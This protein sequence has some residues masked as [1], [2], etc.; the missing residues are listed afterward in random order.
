PSPRPNRSRALAPAGDSES[1]KMVDGA[2]WGDA[3][4]AAPRASTPVRRNRPN[5][6]SVRTRAPRRRASAPAPAPRT[7]PSERSATCRW[8]RPARIRPAGSRRAA[9]APALSAAAGPAVLRGRRVARA[10]GRSGSA[11]VAPEPAGQVRDEPRG[12][13]ERG[14]DL[15]HPFRVGASIAAD[16]PPQRLHEPGAAQVLGSN[17]PGQ[18][19]G[20]ERLGA[21]L[22]LHLVRCAPDA[23]RGSR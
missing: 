8:R 10:W 18:P 21:D 14:D 19:A 4:P 13:V 23:H 3:L 12:A 2:A 11:S 20:R 9:P 5:T 16:R 7:D 17:P 15:A 1:A 22:L 6:L